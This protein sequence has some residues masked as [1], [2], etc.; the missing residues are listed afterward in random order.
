[1]RSISR[2]VL[3]GL[4]ILPALL[5]FLARCTS[6][7]EEKKKWP[8]TYDHG[9]IYISAD[10]SFKPVIDQQTRVYDSNYPGT[11]I[12][13]NYKPEA[14]CLKDFAVD[15]IRMI[16]ATRG[17]TDNEDRFLYD[18]MKVEHSS[19]VI[20]NDAIAVI[21]NPNSPDSFFTMQE[22]KEILTGKFKRKLI[23]VFDGVKATSTVR[24]IV[25]SVL[26]SDSLSPN[27]VAARTSEGVIDYVAK[28]PDA[29]GFIGVSWVGNPEDSMQLGFLKRVKM[30]SLESTDR[31]GGYVLPY[32]A[33][34]YMRRY[35]MVRDLVYILKEN[36]KG[37]G[38]GFSDFLRSTPGQLIFKRAYLFPTLINFNVR[39]ARLNE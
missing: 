25:D 11:K 8:D 19:L 30:A 14:E 39:Q 17:Y 15:S 24:F 5:F 37:L 10:E 20:A 9:T 4:I 6:Y 31:P 38:T 21:V 2:R 33:N 29:I 12:I 23:P 27:T 34:I 3:T 22:L 16:I 32:Q 1:M 18:S 7:E 28:T 13:V 26:H 35:P 36:H